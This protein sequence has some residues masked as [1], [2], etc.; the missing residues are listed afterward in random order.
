VKSLERE[1]RKGGRCRW[2]KKKKKYAPLVIGIAFGIVIARE[3]A[4]WRK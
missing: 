1:D 3:A 4:Y 2:K